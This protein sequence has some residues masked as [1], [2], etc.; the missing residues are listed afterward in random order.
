MLYNVPLDYSHLLLPHLYMFQYFEFQ[1]HLPFGPIITR[2]ISRLGISLDP[3]CITTPTVYITADDVLDEIAIAVEGE[4]AK[5]S[6]SDSDSMNSD[7]SNEEGDFVEEEV[8]EEPAEEEDSEPEEEEPNQN[9]EVHWIN[10]SDNDDDSSDSGSTPLEDVLAA[11]RDA[12][13]FD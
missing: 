7:E 1:G 8:E 6:D 4:D 9:I 10:S 13:G 2:L 3:F 12:Y 11:L 5:D